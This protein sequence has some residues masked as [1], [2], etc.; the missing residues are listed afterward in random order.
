MGRL[1]DAR[2]LVAHL[3]D[4]HTPTPTQWSIFGNQEQREL[5]LSGLRL[6]MGE[7]R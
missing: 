7:E 6:A 2:A 5:V 1:D 3:V 4:E